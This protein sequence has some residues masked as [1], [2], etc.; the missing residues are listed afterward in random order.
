MKQNKKKKIINIPKKSLAYLRN[1][2]Y[3]VTPE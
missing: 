1:N 2:Y 3:I